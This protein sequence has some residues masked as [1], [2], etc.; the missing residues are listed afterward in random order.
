MA[1]AVRLKCNIT[2][3]A[4]FLSAASG[5]AELPLAKE[6]QSLDKR[7][8]SIKSGVLALEQDL[9]MLN[10]D[11]QSFQANPLVVYLSTDIDDIFELQAIELEL[12]G[13]FLIRKEMASNVLLALQHGGTQQ[14]FEKDLTQGE[15]ELKAT[16]F[17]KIGKG[18]PYQTPV[19]VT[20]L[21]E[22]QPKIVELRVSNVRERFLPTIDPLQ[23]D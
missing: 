22:K 15:Y 14:I 23:W 17:G 21:K 19:T 11:A 9:S 16:I 1:G 13:T 6:Y 3:L 4:L 2:L 8:Q 20:F 10:K 5:A 18:R 12:N 7:I